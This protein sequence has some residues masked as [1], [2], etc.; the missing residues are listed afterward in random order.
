LKFPKLHNQILIAL[1]AG[2]IFGSIFNVNQN[3]L[4]IK[5]NK[6]QKVI[7]DWGQFLF[8]T[9]SDSTSFGRDSQLEIVAFYK[10]LSKSGNEISARVTGFDDGNS[11]EKQTGYF[12]NIKSITRESSIAT[13]NN[14]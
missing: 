9:G 7:N 8:V 2:A 3:T 11:S 1:V 10:K 5:Y 14:G 6:E 4:V 13:S 12:T